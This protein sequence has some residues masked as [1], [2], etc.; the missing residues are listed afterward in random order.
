[1]EAGTNVPI[2]HIVKLRLKEVDFLESCSYQVAESSY[3]LRSVLSPAVLLSP[4][5]Q[6]K[7][8]YLPPQLLFLFSM[9]IWP[10][11]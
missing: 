8:F 11:N 4:C 7:S 10:E 9:I 5:W 3:A 2:L 6:P 1:M